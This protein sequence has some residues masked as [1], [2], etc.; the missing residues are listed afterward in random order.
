MFFTIQLMLNEE[1]NQGI[2]KCGK[3]RPVTFIPCAISS[4]P[5]VEFRSR[6]KYYLLLNQIDCKTE[7]VY[8][9]LS[10]FLNS[11]V[12]AKKHL[13]LFSS[14]ENIQDKQQ[15]TFNL[16]QYVSHIFPCRVL[17]LPFLAL[18]Q[19]KLQT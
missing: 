6:C 16:I 1:L 17:V 12:G 3:I 14:K 8:H 11:L 7:N 19:A 5:L 2:L 13:M 4:F 15:L 10:S 18:F 9:L